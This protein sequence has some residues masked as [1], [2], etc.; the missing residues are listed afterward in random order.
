M[1]HTEAVASGI[2][3]NGNYVSFVIETYT[4]LQPFN[5]ETGKAFNLVTLFSDVLCNNELMI[6]WIWNEEETEE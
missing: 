5:I 1:K 3:R 2:D 6:R 4:E